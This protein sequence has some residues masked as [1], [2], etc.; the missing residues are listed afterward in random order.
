MIRMGA[1]RGRWRVAVGLA[2][3]VSA[4]GVVAGNYDVVHAQDNV[5]QLFMRV[6]DA[7]GAPVTDLQAADF[8]IEEGGVACTV[9]QSEFINAPLRLAIVLDD[10]GGAFGYRQYL[11]RALPQFLDGLPDGQIALIL[12]AGRPQTAVDYTDGPEKLREAIEGF[13]VE[14]TLAS[15]L[16]DGLVESID[17]LTD[18]GR[19]PVMAII[20]TDGPEDSTFSD[21]RAENLSDKLSEHSVTVHSVVLQTL[22]G[23]SFQPNYAEFLSNA[24]GGWHDVLASA[25]AALTDKLA[26]MAAEISRRHAE[27]SNR[28]VVTI[29]RPD[30]PEGSSFAIGVT[31]EGLTLLD[32]SFD[33][34]P[35]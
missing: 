16:F 8:A 22:R 7:T 12:L 25:S 3:V 19:W 32:A 15:T 17:D 33:G 11:R 30:V 23:N 35:R 18:E 2:V 28:Y 9:V 31:R 26:E 4:G 10:S 29:E 27:A 6:V 34:R 21:R 1:R 24:T 13:F 5:V 14:R 20:T